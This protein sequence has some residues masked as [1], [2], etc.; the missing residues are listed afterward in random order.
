M[1]PVVELPKANPAPGRPVPMC[2]TSFKSILEVWAE[3]AVPL[4]VHPGWMK[5]FPWL[6]QGTT[7]SGAPGQEGGTESRDFRL[8]QAGPEEEAPRIVPGASERWEKLARAVDMPR[9]VHSRQVHGCAVHS[10]DSPRERLTVVEDGDGHVTATPGILLSV[11][12]ADEDSLPALRVPPPRPAP[13][14]GSF[15]LWGL[16]RGGTGGA[17]GPGPPGARASCPGGPQISLGGAGGGSRSPHLPDHSLF[18]LHPLRRVSPL[19]PPGRGWRETAGS[20]GS[21]GGGL[22][23][24]LLQEVHEDLQRL[25]GLLLR[26]DVTTLRHD[27]E[28]CVRDSPF[29]LLRHPEGNDPIGLSP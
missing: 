22:G 19:L 2:D 5:D 8:F 17:L 12:V 13:P 20:S 14:H 28:P 3:S 25:L 23:A 27:F 15:H 24:C 1:W 11:T 18:P 6:L 4:L 10:H 9:I 7:A 16:L 21:A 29:Q 26:R